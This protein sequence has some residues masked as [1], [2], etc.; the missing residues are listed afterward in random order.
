M[1]LEKK[2]H[3]ERFFEKLERHLVKNT[4][5]QHLSKLV[6]T[7]HGRMPLGYKLKE[8]RGFKNK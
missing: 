8:G 5:Q 4:V 2:F 1:G 7:R 3:E 6:Q